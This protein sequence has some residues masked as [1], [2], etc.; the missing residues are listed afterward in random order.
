MKKLMTLA[1]FAVVAITATACSGC[2]CWPQKDCCEETCDNGKTCSYP[3]G[4]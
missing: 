2:G 3:K 1:V 4:A